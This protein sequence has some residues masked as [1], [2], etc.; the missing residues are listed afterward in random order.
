MVIET[1]Y[2]HR[3][4]SKPTL[5]RYT[6]GSVP[7]H[8]LHV[9]VACYWVFFLGGGLLLLLFFVVVVVFSFAK[10]PDHHDF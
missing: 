5:P 10:R 1:T 6:V 9:R 7:G 4:L 8:C 3:L 2:I